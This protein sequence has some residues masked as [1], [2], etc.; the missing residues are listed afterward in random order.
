MIRSFAVGR[1]TVAVISIEDLIVAKLLWARESH[2]ARQL[3]DVHRLLESE[4]DSELLT[5]RVRRLGLSVL[6]EEARDARYD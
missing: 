5:A 4:L 2:S 6:L 1:A 3:G